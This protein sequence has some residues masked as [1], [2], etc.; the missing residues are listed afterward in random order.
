MVDSRG[1]AKFTF[2]LFRCVQVCLGAPWTNVRSGEQF[3]F[4]ESP[5][6]RDSLSASLISGGGTGYNFQQQ[7]SNV[8]L[9]NS[10]YLYVTRIAVK[11]GY[12]HLT[13]GVCHVEMLTSTRNGVDGAISD[14]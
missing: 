14:S 9:S 11:Q 2:D 13:N 1:Y 5:P 4:V 10:Q 6:Q 3:V 7:L 8:S 12:V